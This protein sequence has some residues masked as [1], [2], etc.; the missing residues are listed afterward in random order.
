MLSAP[1]FPVKF[2]PIP[3]DELLEIRKQ[4]LLLPHAVQVSRKTTTNHSVS[5]VGNV[6]LVSLPAKL[7]YFS[8]GKYEK[9]PLP[10]LK[11]VQFSVFTIFSLYSSERRR[12][13][14]FIF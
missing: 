1:G 12:K 9:N 13:A 8:G 3:F 14:D 4:L 11:S 6:G 5:C 10:F 7:L 2:P